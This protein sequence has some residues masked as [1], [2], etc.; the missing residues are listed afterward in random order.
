MKLMALSKLV[1][2]HYIDQS[3]PVFNAGELGVIWLLSSNCKQLL[4]IETV[5]TLSETRRVAL[6]IQSDQT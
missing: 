6:F 2:I 5:E 1:L 3:E 4:P